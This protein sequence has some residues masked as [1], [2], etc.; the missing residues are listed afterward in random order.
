MQIYIWPDPINLALQILST[1]VLIS[2]VA[3]FYKYIIKKRGKVCSK[4][5]YS[6]MV[7]GMS[8]TFGIGLLVGWLIYHQPSKE[9]CIG[10]VNEESES[11]Y[12]DKCINNLNPDDGLD[13]DNIWLN[14]RMAPQIEDEITLEAKPDYVI[15]IHSTKM[16]VSFINDSVWLTED[17]AI[18]G[19]QTAATTIIENA[20]YL[21]QETLK[22]LIDFINQHN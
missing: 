22:H 11:V 8:T 18:I 15:D 12:Y 1:L 5:L 17:S 9:L 6:I 2:L 10:S 3:L 4:K 16:G 21:S 20:R 14:F 7:I 13:I 19:N